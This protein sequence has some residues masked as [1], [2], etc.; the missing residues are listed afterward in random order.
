MPMP[1]V[2]LVGPVIRHPTPDEI[3]VHKFEQQQAEQELPLIYQADKADNESSVSGEASEMSV[4]KA[5][6]RANSKPH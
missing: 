4:E 2:D 3:T 6:T 5:P 1:E